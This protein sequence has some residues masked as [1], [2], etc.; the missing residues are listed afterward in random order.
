MD[1]ALKKNVLHFAEVSIVHFRSRYF[2]SLMHAARLVALN[3][4]GHLSSS[5]KRGRD[6]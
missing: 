1:D 5:K 6:A 2:L 4:S 3:T